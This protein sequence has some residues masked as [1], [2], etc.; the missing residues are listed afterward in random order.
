M[1]A[2]SFLDYMGLRD[3]P[4][5]WQMGADLHEDFYDTGI[6]FLREHAEPDPL[7]RAMLHPGY[8]LSTWA[9]VDALILRPGISVTHQTSDRYGGHQVSGPIVSIN[10]DWVSVD[11]GA[12][13]GYQRPSSFPLAD[14]NPERDTARVPVP[15]DA[16]T[17]VH[18]EVRIG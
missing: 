14:W 10:G 1:T 12:N 6:A 17:L 5:F 11:V 8:R 15:L 3:H 7:L 16:A 18:E 2:E 13:P 4:D 9:H